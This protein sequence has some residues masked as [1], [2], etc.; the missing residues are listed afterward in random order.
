MQA[1][2]GENTVPE[3]TV[4]KA[5]FHLGY[6]YRLHRRDLPGK[7]DIAFPGRKKVI[8]VHGCFWHRHSC[9]RGAR[10]PK[11]NQDYWLPKLERNKN[12]DK[13]NEAL[14][15]EKGWR[16]LTVWECELKDMDALMDKMADFLDH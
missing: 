2:K 5:L 11:T 10:K 16:V 13:H 8:F 7:P 12:R 3:V 4:R 1:V 9:K 6:R 14:L 15:I